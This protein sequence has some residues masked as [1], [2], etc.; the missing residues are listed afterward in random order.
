MSKRGLFILPAV[1]FILASCITIEVEDNTVTPVLTEGIIT[2]ATDQ[3]QIILPSFTPTPEPI[4]PTP[5]F[6]PSPL[7]LPTNTPLATSTNTYVS[8]EGR[9]SINVPLHFSLYVGQVPSVD[10]VLVAVPN[11]VSLQSQI[12]PPMLVTI[13]YFEIDQAANLEDFFTE[14]DPC[15]A[16][17][18]GRDYE[19]IDGIEAILVTDTPCGPYGYSIYA[20][21]RSE[22]GY[23]IQVEH[24]EV[25]E[26]VKEILEPLIETFHTLE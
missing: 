24:F 2:L 18:P 6:T 23:L 26:E 15:A 20:L 16:S 17:I 4:I 11:A 22:Y 3:P 21:V 13:R 9:F 12:S 8:V 1:M 25:F 10:G 7:P 19:T 14:Q 5:T